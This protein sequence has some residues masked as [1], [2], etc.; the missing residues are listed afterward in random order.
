MG[1]FRPTALRPRPFFQFVCHFANAQLSPILRLGMIRYETC[2]HSQQAPGGS[3]HVRIGIE[4][5]LGRQDGWIGE[6]VSKKSKL[7]SRELK[8]SWRKNIR[9]QNGINCVDGYS[10]FVVMPW[11]I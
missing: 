4:S 2:N 9:P 6:S 10:H 8:F 1:R 3:R 5:A 7:R 11:W